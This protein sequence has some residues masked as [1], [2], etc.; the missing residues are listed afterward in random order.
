MARRLALALLASLAAGCA[1]DGVVTFEGVCDADP[2]LTEMVAP[3]EAHAGTALALDPRLTSAQ[4]AAVERAAAA[5]HDATGGAVTFTLVRADDAPYTV[6]RPATLVA[7]CAADAPALDG[8]AAGRTYLAE[9]GGI[10][11][12]LDAYPEALWPSLVAHEL[13]HRMG[14][15]HSHDPATLMYPGLDTHAPAPTPADVAAWRALAGRP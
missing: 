10:A 1:L 5:W 13:G 14:L 8:W 2:D 3:A 12:A 9:T 15:K 7:R 6:G 11:L 4:A